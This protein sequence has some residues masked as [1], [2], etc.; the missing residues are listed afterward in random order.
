VAGELSPS[1]SAASGGRSSGSGS[2]AAVIGPNYQV[3]R[4]AQDAVEG[5]AALHHVSR[6]GNG[7][8]VFCSSSGGIASMA[9]AQR[10]GFPVNRK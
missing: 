4:P 10:S 9:Y 2:E 7:R 5:P 3:G 1:P 8:S 6:M